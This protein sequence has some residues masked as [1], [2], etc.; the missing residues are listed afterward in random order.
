MKKNLLLYVLL[1]FLIIVNGF[2]LYNYIGKS[3]V[4]NGKNNKN[5]L[6][7]IVEELQFDDIQKKK[8]EALNEKHHR[9]MMRINDDMKVFKDGL[10]SKIFD[11][12]IEKQEIDSLNRLI[13][14]KE[15]ELNKEVFYH[16]RAIQ[17]ICTKE[18]KKKFKKIIKD[19]LKG[20]DKNNRRPPP[21]GNGEGQGRPPMEG[22]DRRPP[23][24]N[25]RH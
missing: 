13:T 6:N 20:G 14:K 11:E 25:N 22:D 19:V 24:P 2:F 23:P 7:F 21:N 4:V 1:I 5:P 8:A 9:R 16:F 3:E 10:M 15:L 18:Q 17:D 12:S